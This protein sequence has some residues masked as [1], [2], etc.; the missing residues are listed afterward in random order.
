MAIHS[1][2]YEQ[3]IRALIILAPGERAKSSLSILPKTACSA[4]VFTLTVPGDFGLL[5]RA[6][7]E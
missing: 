3:G 6:I 5:L 7:P 2:Y 1:P 4:P